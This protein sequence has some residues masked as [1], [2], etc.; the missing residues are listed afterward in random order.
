M[1]L[2]DWYFR[3]EQKIKWLTTPGKTKQTS[4]QYADR[5]DVFLSATGTLQPGRS[6]QEYNLINPLFVNTP[7]EDVVK[8]Y[9]LVRTRLM[10][11]EPRTCYSIHRDQS[12]RLHI[13]LVTNEDCKFIFPEESEMFYLP[14]GGAYHV[15][16][17]K[18]HSFCNFSA[19]PRLHLL[20]CVY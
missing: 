9:K 2:A 1:Q 18:T 13:P 20:G 19:E 15:N 17:N 3:H 16:T 12:V 6:E 10:W 14:V 11:L 5:D 8:E 4:I 7:F